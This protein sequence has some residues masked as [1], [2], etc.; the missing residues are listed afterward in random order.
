MPITSYLVEPIQGV[1]GYM[2]G[3]LFGH[4]LQ[5]ASSYVYGMIS[6]SSSLARW[7]L[8]FALVTA[9]TGIAL[10]G[11]RMIFMLPHM[12]HCPFGVVWITYLGV[13]NNLQALSTF[14]FVDIQSHL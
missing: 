1:V 11:V 6:T 7:L 8:S 13:F 5:M 2:A 10:A 4:L 14:Y 3:S 9:D 12:A